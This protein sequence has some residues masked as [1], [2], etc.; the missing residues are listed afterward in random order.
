MNKT[1][2]DCYKKSLAAAASRKQPKLINV[3]PE[4]VN[5]K[6]SKT[7]HKCTYTGLPTE[8][9]SGGTYRSGTGSGANPFK[10]TIDR[11]DPSKG[12]T[13]SNI[14]PASWFANQM[15]GTLPAPV[16]E[17]AVALVASKHFEELIDKRKLKAFKALLKH[18]ETTVRRGK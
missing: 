4:Q 13:L 6:F 16:F 15:K 17:A 9:K 5:K 1:Y 3:T 12:Y 10:I 11:S 8:T 14:K 7:K 18:A 2:F